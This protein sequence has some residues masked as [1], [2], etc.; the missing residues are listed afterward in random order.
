MH[1]GLAHKK[2]SSM[3]KL[4]WRPGS[5][6]GDWAG[7]LF[8]GDARCRVDRPGPRNHGTNC[9]VGMEVSL[10][11]AVMTSARPRAGRRFEPVAELGLMVEARKATRRLP[12]ARA[13]LLVLDDVAGPYGVPDLVAVT[14]SAEVLA[15]RQALSV[16]PLLNQ[17]D[18]SIAAVTSPTSARS[19]QAIAR[20][21]G[22]PSSTVARRI[23]ALLRSGALEE[24]RSGTFVRPKDLVPI[25][26]T[27]AIELK[28]RDWQRALHQGRSYQLWTDAY[29]LVMPTISGYAEMSLVK[30]AI[31]DRSGVVINGKWKVRPMIDRPEHIR[32]LWGSEHVLAAMGGQVA[33]SLP[34]PR[35]SQAQQ[36]GSQSIGSNR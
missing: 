3:S 27:F 25:G 15:R 16:P 8:G 1:L 20:R 6:A 14:G 36:G 34:S 31:T 2:R 7:P 12:G 30:A 18:A 17:V 9:R 26:R 19:V 5:K 33:K 13:G 10:L 23:S 24:W 32:S 29:V 22:W 11:P 35:T 4:G 21:L 28:V